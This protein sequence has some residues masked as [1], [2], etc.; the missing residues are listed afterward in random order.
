MSP[1]RTKE[2][3]DERILVITTN[4]TQQQIDDLP[5]GGIILVRETTA[6]TP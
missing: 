2:F 4:P 6:Y 5:D 3:F 1:L